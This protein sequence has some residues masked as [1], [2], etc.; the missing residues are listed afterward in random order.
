[1]RSGAAFLIPNP[2]SSSFETVSVRTSSSGFLPLI[3]SSSDCRSF[4]VLL[5]PKKSNCSVG[6]GFGL[7]ATSSA[8]SS[9]SF[10]ITSSTSSGISTPVFSSTTAA[11]SAVSSFF[12]FFFLSFFGSGKP[13]SNC[14]SSFAT[15]SVSASSSVSNS[16]CAFI[17]FC[18]SSSMSSSVCMSASV[19]RLSGMK[20][21]PKSNSL[22]PV[23][24]SIRLATLR[25]SAS[26]AASFSAFSLASMSPPKAVVV[27][28]I[29][30]PTRPAATATSTYVSRASS[31][32][33]GKPA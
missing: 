23:S 19:V 6:S 7:T 21:G 33:I 22:C 28:L 3:S 9:S 11:S 32:A 8:S 24:G 5:R 16:V 13:K 1:M 25:S 10:S 18:I 30:P 15:V 29:V 31:L 12:F 4:S 2:S 14:L 17:M 27:P 20:S 26:R